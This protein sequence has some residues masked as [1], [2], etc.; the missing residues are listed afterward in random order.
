MADMY[1]ADNDAANAEQEERDRRSRQDA[2][3]LTAVYAR[4]A[5][6]GAGEF[7]ELVDMLGLDEELL[8]VLQRRRP[9]LVAI[10][11]DVRAISVERAAGTVEPNGR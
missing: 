1:F 9:K 7:V 6:V 10:V 3:L 4:D 2:M 8:T 5:Q 11:T